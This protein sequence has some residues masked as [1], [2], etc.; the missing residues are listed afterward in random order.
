MSEKLLRGILM[1]LLDRKSRDDKARILKEAGF[2][3]SEIVEFIGI[4]E[5]A[6]RMRKSRAK[7]KNG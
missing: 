7:K 6:K 5:T 1:T 3:K 4:S 2:K